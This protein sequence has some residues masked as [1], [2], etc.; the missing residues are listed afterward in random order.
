MLRSNVEVLRC[1]LYLSLSLSLPPSSPPS[2]PRVRPGVRD[3][4]SSRRR[5]RK[6]RFRRAVL[7]QCRQRP[8]R[9][10]PMQCMGCIGV[11]FLQVY[12][13]PAKSLAD[14][15]S[16]APERLVWAAP[17]AN[18]PD[19]RRFGVT[20][21]RFLHR[22]AFHPAARRL[23][24]WSDG[25]AG[26]RRAGRGTLASGRPPSRPRARLKSRRRTVQRGGAGSPDCGGCRAA[27][28]GQR[29]RLPWPSPSR[30]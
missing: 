14:T 5:L 11:G 8:P 19:C 28:R 17:S 18:L 4:S 7:N 29:A 30:P 27:R 22:A 23:R 6:D 24:P 26:S 12:R 25:R 21:A 10:T 13:R 2:F 1:C 15:A 20:T 9:A 16:S 3:G